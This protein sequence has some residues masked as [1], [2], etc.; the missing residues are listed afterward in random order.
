ML[1]DEP[2]SGARVVFVADTS[3]L[4]SEDYALSYGVTD[5]AGAFTLKLADGTIGAL[6]GNHRVYISKAGSSSKDAITE[7]QNEQVGAW[8]LS[9]R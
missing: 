2:V 3:S 6:A 4:R 9:Q 1:D 7:A 5:D 8:L